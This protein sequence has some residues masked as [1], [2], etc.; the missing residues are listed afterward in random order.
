ML[1]IERLIQIP[2]AFSLTSNKIAR[3][4]YWLSTDYVKVDTWDRPKNRF[5]YI[6]ALEIELENGIFLEMDLDGFVVHE[7]PERRAVNLGI[8]LTYHSNHQSQLERYDGGCSFDASLSE[9]WRM[10]I[11]HNADS[12]EIYQN[13][14][15]IKL[16]GNAKIF[17]IHGLNL[18]ITDENTL[19]TSYP[20]CM[21]IKI[22]PIESIY[23]CTGTYIENEDK[24]SQSLGRLIVISSKE[25][26]KYYGIGPYCGLNRSN[27]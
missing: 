9:A 19:V 21:E 14:E 15:A 18:E 13:S 27:I 20:A 5:D 16:T 25:V 1:K 12:V 17:E 7:D 3:V 26:A 2:S 22:S 24:I 6:D 23:I 11:N 8:R 10:S 4:I